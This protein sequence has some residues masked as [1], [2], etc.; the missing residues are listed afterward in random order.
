MIVKTKLKIDLQRPGQKNMIYAMQNDQN[1]RIVEISLFSGGVAWHIPDGTTFAVGYEKADGTSGIY[2]TLPDGKTKAVTFEGNVITAILA[3]QVLT[4]FGDVPVGVAL[5]DSNLNRLG[6]FPFVVRVEE[7][8]SAG[9]TESEDYYWLSTLAAIGNMDD[10]ETKDKSSLVAAINEVAQSGGGGGSG[11]NMELPCHISYNLVNAVSNNYVSTVNKG[12]DFEVSLTALEGYAFTSVKIIH[13]GETVVDEAYN[14]PITGYDWGIYGENSGVQGDIVVIAVAE[15][16][17]SAGE[18]GKDGEDGFSPIAKVTQ[19]STGATISITDKSG[20]TTATIA[21]GKDG[22][23]GVDGQ[24]GYTPQKNVDYFDGKDGKD[25]SNGKDGTSVTVKSVSESTVDGGSNVV[26]FSDG[27]TLTVKN[28]KTGAKGDK[29]DTYTITDADKQEIAGMVDAVPS[30]VVTEAEAVLNRVLSSQGSRTFTLAV[31][32]DMHYGSGGN[33]DGLK[34]ASQALKCIADRIEL[35][36][37]AVLGDYTDLYINENYA[38]GM[39]DVLAVNSLLSGVDADML[40]LCGNHDFHTSKSPKVMRTISGKSDNVVWGSRTGGYYHRDFD[41]YKLRVIALNTSETEGSNIRC[42]AE[43][44]NWFTSTLDMS[45]KEDA[46]EWQILIL[47][48]HPLDWYEN[49]NDGA[50]RFAHILDAYTNGK[51]WSGGGVSCN[52]AEK[53]AARIIGNV[54]GHIHNLLVDRIRLGNPANST[55]QTDI[56]RLCMPEACLDRP[57]SYGGVWDAETVYAKTANTAT[58]TAFTVLCIDL[59]N[60]TINA[61]NYGAGIDRTV[62][63]H[64]PTK[65]KYKNMLESA[66]NSDGTPYRGTNGEIGYKAGYRLNSSGAEAQNSDYYVTGYIPI[67]AWDYVYLK[68]MNLV[69]GD[70]TAQ[71]NTRVVTYDAQFKSKR[72]AQTGEGLLS[73]EIFQ[74]LLDENGGAAEVGDAIGRLRYV[75]GSDDT[76][77]YYIRFSTK[78]IDATSIVTVNEPI[79]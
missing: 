75:E 34:H 23:D 9:S 2:D 22:K 79:E 7:D 14:M 11:S 13:N 60:Y 30:Y 71:P 33:T 18:D 68:N 54:H 12:D 15:L 24:D 46:D 3:T 21:N 56:Y 76:V 47:S 58:D 28:G 55:E 35:D 51:S 17:G 53:N 64:D 62:I 40:T 43:Q 36:A 25:G 66:I 59:D 8:P 63:Y 57:Q 61:V 38:N 48:H 37:M 73:S 67:H 32:T 44:Y 49:A 70:T 42:S 16:V 5:F 6:V 69:I 1:T 65:P 39:A 72:I 10:L 26:T 20:T 29:G 45:E 52:F 77:L 50:Y 19:T 41:D 74:N 31:L 27:K 4:S 78:K